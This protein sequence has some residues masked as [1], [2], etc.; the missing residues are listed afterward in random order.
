MKKEKK[1]WVY[2]ITGIVAVLAAMLYF[3]YLSTT[4]LDW[5]E[6]GEHYC[7]FSAGIREQQSINS[8]GLSGLIDDSKRRFSVDRELWICGE[9][10]VEIKGRVIFEIS[11]G[12]NIL[13]RREL[14]SGYNIIDY[15]WEHSGDKQYDFRVVADTGEITSGH[16]TYNLYERMT[17]WNKLIWKYKGGDKKL[18]LRRDDQLY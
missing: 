10:D 8:E 1:R 18:L 15:Q 4:K 12:E 5:R 14:H 11:E 2:I 13:Y 17:K 9:I 16:M 6:I 3:L 7:D